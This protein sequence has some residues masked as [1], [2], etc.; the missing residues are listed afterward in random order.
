MGRM[1]R[2]RIAERRIRVDDQSRALL[3]GEVHF[4]RLDPRVWPSV[5]ARARE[6]GLDMLSSYV[7]W[8]FHELAPGRFDLRGETTPRRDLLAFLELVREQ[9]FWLVLRPGPY[10]YAEWPNSGVPERVVRWHRLHPS[11]QHAAAAWLAAVVDAARPFL[12][13]H[14][15][16]VVLLQAD[17]EADPWIDVYAEQLGLGSRT[18]L[19]Q[20]FLAGRYAH[21]AELNRAWEAAYPDFSAARAVLSPVLRAGG[22]RERYLDVCRFRH[23]YAREIVRWTTAE[24][25]R[26]GVD[27]PISANTYIGLDVQDW[28]EIEASCD[29]AGPDVYPTSRVADDPQERRL[30]L[31]AVRFTRTY[32]ALP[33]IPEFEAGIWH[34]WH[35][36]VGTLGATHCVFNALSVLQAG[37]CGWNW[38][39]LA[40]R[41]SW[42]MSPIT[43]LGRLRPD[44]APAFETVV[45][46]FREL[47]PPSLEKLS[48]TAVTLDVLERAA[49]A[50]GAG[51]EV[52]RALDAADIDYELFDL[53]TGRLR[54]PLVLYA[55][56][57]WLSEAAQARLV[58]YVESGGSLV[59]FHSLPRGRLGLWP[60]DGITT[61]ADPQRLRLELGGQSVELS[62]PAVFAYA[63]VP[64]EALVAE[65]VAPRAPTQEGGHAHVRLPVGQRI[66]IGY[67]ERRGSGRLVVMGVVPTPELL[68]ALHPWLGVSIPCRAL[69]PG[70][71]SA[72]FRRGLEYV[73]VLTNTSPEAREA[74]LRLE[75][76]P[77]PRQA[78][79]LLTGCRTPVVDGRVLVRVPA[80][81]GTAIQLS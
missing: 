26:L 46:V 34:G 15:G 58:E 68:V 71:R 48:A 3:S 13:T 29:L 75:L 51:E 38:Y 53:E 55:G 8:D 50:E 60:P 65:R 17:N 69:S 62:S 56:D 30:V 23:W 7:C 59:F 27:V 72:V 20:E 64:G 37:A 25:R 47:D 66:T 81:S 41:D 9:G 40:G 18:G 61:A 11:F 44:L 79:D 2:A 14:G 73:A 4:W 70:V 36:R 16:P 39:M 12:A 52:P 22:Y 33:F 5:L 45:R 6:L 49:G 77:L 10:I 32:S 19:F 76:E 28:R 63:D 74:S 43:E 1:A 80:R 42:Y 78:R 35:T 24:Y 54:R 21:I 31:D 57:A 67:V